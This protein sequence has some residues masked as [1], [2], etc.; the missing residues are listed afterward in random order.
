MATE[1]SADAIHDPVHGAAYTFR[2]DGDDLWVTAW[3]ED[4]GHLPEHLHPTL[5]E[6]WE[7]LDG[8]VRLRLDGT[9]RDVTAADGPM[10]VAPGVRHALRNTSGSRAHLRCR[11][12]PAGDLQE[13]LTESAAAAR[14]GM[15]SKGGLPTSLAAAGWVARFALRFRHETIMCSP[16]PALQRIALPLLA[17]I[18]RDAPEGATPRTA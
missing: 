14:A 17:R 10:R 1:I 13:F 5:D 8:T 18:G 6:R 11:V 15:L 4:G 9:W 3:L 7:V 16:P 2:R 12:S